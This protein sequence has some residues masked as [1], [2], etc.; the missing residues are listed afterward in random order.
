MRISDWSSDVCYSDLWAM[1]EQLQAPFEGVL[2]LDET[3]F[4]GARKGK[5]GWCAAGKVAVL[6]LITR[7]GQ[8][9]IMPI[10]A[11]DRAYVMQ[12]IDAH[13]REGSLTTRTSGRPTP[14]PRRLRHAPLSPARC[15]RRYLARHC[16]RSG[17][18][19]RWLLRWIALLCAWCRCCR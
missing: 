8:A 1:T 5:R 6:G 13:S 10:A 11:H 12:Q 16:L 7:N 4:G 9:K 3:T 17:Y 19:V 2:E 14:C 18:S 15:P